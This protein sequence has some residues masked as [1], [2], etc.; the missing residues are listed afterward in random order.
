MDSVFVSVYIISSWVDACLLIMYWI[1]YVCMNMVCI[2]F[3]F[4]DKVHWL[5]SI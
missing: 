5:S 3:L 1:F 2:S 4:V